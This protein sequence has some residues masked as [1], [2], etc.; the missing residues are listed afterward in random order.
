MTNEATRVLRPSLPSSRL[1]SDALAHA[2]RL[3][4]EIVALFRSC[5]LAVR[6]VHHQSIV[7]EGNQH[8]GILLMLSGAAAISARAGDAEAQMLA[9]LFP[10]D[11]VSTRPLA[12]LQG[13]TVT[14][15][16]TSELLKTR[17]VNGIARGRDEARLT[18]ILHEQAEVMW[19][20]AAVHALTIASLDAEQRIATFMV[21]IALRLGRFSDERVML[22]LPMLR[23][24]IARYLAL[25]ADTLS[26]TLTRVKEQGLVSF[27]GRRELVIPDWDKLCAATPLATTL[28][29]VHRRAGDGG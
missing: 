7:A 23:S 4:D 24:D 2:L 6:S 9:I 17:P 3:D 28:L 1:L 13:T 16:G 8:D 5:G 11:I 19:S 29:A 22:T 18:A 26:R 27:Y 15:L 14:S 21:E 20:R 10:G 12:A 25:N